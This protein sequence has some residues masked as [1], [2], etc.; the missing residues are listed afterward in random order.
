MAATLRAARRA[1]L[2]RRKETRDQ[3]GGNLLLKKEARRWRPAGQ[4]PQGARAGYGR[5]RHSPGFAEA[6]VFTFG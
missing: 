4:M 3:R 2:G 5:P 1:D 6:D